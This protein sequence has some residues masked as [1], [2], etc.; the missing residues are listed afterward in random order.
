LKTTAAGG[1]ALV[2]SRLDLLDSPQ[3]QAAIMDPP[4][5]W[6]GGP[7]QARYRIDGLAKVTGQK[8]YARDFRARDVAG[9]PAPEEHVFI[10]RAPFADRVFAGVSTD[11][12]PP[13]I[14]PKRVVTAADLKR[15]G[16]GIAEEDYP[17]GMYLVPEG[18]RPDHLGQPVALL[19]FD[20][21]HALQRARPRLLHAPEAIRTAGDAS[22]PAPTDYEPQTS[23]IHVV[24][25]GPQ[26]YAVR[27]RFAQTLGGPVR[28]TD[29][30]QRNADAMQYVDLIGEKLEASGWE[31]H[32]QT[33]TT[34]I[35]DPMFMEPESGLAWL[36]RSSETLHLLIGSQSPE[37]D[38][39]SAGELFAPEGCAIKV[40]TVR[41]TACYPGGGF[42]GRDTS[43]LCLYLGLAA[44]YSDR[45]IRIAYDRFEQFQTGVK[46]HA[47]KIDLTLGIDQSGRFQAV[48]NHTVLNGGG[49]INVSAYVAQ[50]AAIMGA[51][52]YDFPLADIWSRAEHTR[53]I[54]AGSIRAFG[55]ETPSF[56]IESMV[57]EIAEGRKID[58]IELRLRNL[59]RPGWSI[60][61]GAPKAPAGLGEICERA[62]A[63]PL[64]R[65]RE[66][67]RAARSH[68]DLAYGVGFALAMKNYGTGAD[69]VFQGVSIDDRGRIAVTTHAVDMG[70]GTATTLA[71]TTARALGANADEVKTGEI[72]IFDELGMVESF[73]PQPDN[74]RWTP[75]TFMSH[76]AATTSSRWVF[77]VD[78]TSQILFELGLMPA[79]RALWGRAARKLAARDTQWKDGRLTARGLRPLTLADIARRAHADR[80]VVAVLTHAFFSAKWVEADYAVDGETRRWPIDALG[81]LRA[82][83]ADYE[84]VERKNS[85]LYTVESMW[86]GNGQTFGAAGCLLAVE[87]DRRSGAV[88]VVEGVHY[89]APGRV[90]MRDFVEGQ[91]DGSFAFGVGYALLEDLPPYED[92]AAD[93]KWNLNRYHV[94]LARDC[95]IRTMEKVILPPESPDAPARGVAEVTTC[96]VAPAIANAVAHA[97]GKRFRT[98]PITPESVRAALA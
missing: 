86:E 8:I 71:I 67:K 23:I 17:E 91:M 37:Y 81:V 18:E 80:G 33:Y 11:F 95:A 84:V 22:I 15:D 29:P 51:G 63:H 68:A 66:R 59:L 54:V 45:P 62:R 40:R 19:F 87:V 89:V 16:I 30:G 73:D 36:D 32:R 3:A 20:D 58:P 74:P 42:G 46:R 2:V 78:T 77:G 76:K 93:G 12:L 70:T 90:L 39:R 10:L 5:G 92:G 25:D 56:A 53:S 28:P 27:E 98:L 96:P 34:Q 38:A 65:E 49:R 7:G 48:R 75:I 97:T 13:E 43:I 69:A 61:T 57:D 35:T 21:V 6:K 47:A 79:A 64:W 55:A 83:S 85:Q 82:G 41:F 60:V 50:V 9:W 1:I 52:S 44:A 24:R 14:R 94:P 31:I 26:P 88:R 4:G 72:E